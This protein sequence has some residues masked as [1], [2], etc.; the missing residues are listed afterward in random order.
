MGVKE[1]GLILVVDIVVEVTIELLKVVL[2]VEVFGEA[3]LFF[4]VLVTLVFWCVVVTGV[5]LV[6]CEKG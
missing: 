2:E 5:N 4:V 1:S 6:V 3:G